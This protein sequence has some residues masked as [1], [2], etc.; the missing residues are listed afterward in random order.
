MDKYYP[1]LRDIWRRNSTVSGSFVCYSKTSDD[2]E[3][4]KNKKLLIYEGW[5]VRDEGT[6]GPF[7]LMKELNVFY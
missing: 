2:A 7:I 3:F 4:I 6:D 5:E 1:T